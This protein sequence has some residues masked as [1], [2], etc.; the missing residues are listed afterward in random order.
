ENFS[1]TLQRCCHA[2]VF[3]FQFRRLLQRLD[4][5][6]HI[7]GFPH[8]AKQDE[9]QDYDPEADD[10]KRW[11]IPNTKESYRGFPYIGCRAAEDCITKVVT[12]GSSSETNFWIEHFNEKG[13]ATPAIHR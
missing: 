7:S 12:K 13:V 11:S 1:E 2:W 3:S 9:Q 5:I 6:F 8:A 10:V 4:L